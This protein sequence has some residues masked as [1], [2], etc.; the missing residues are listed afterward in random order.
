MNTRSLAV[1]LLTGIATL[2]CAKNENANTDKGNGN[3]ASSGF[4]VSATV[5]GLT[6]TGLVLTL[7]S[8]TDIAVSAN[9]TVS[10]AGS[11]AGGA[12]YAVAVKTQPVNPDQICAVAN[13]SG[14]ITGGNVTNIAIT[15]EVTGWQQ[16][17]YVKASNANGSDSFGSAVAIE[18]D[19]MVVGAYAEDSDSNTILQGSTAS[20]SNAG[21][22]NGAAYVFR[23]TGNIW[24][25]EAYLKPSNMDERDKFGWAVAISNGRIAVAAPDE[26][27]N[28]TTI[29]H[30]STASSNNT[31]ANAGAVYIFE[32]NGT[33]WEQK[34]YIKAPNAAAGH[35]FGYALAM[36]GDTLVVGA[37]GESSAQTTITNGPTASTDTSTANSG[38]VYVYRRT[39][40][41]WAQEAYIK[42]GN[43]EYLD[44]FGYS[45]SISGDAIV[46]GAYN[47]DSGQ[48]TITNGSGTSSDNSITNS[49]AVYVY[50]RSGVNWSQEAYIKAPN[51]DA[52]DLFGYM[53][54]ISGDTILVGAGGDDSGQ[55]TITNGT[56]ASTDNSVIEAGAAYIYRR[57]AG[58]WSQEAY[59]KA[60]NAESNDGFGYTIALQGNV[61][62]VSC[63]Y[64]DSS[65]TTVTNGSTASSDNSVNDTGAAFIFRRNGT[66]WS[67]EAYLKPPVAQ[68]NKW[69][70]EAG[71]SIS[72]DT[73]AVYA[74]G[75]SSNQNTITNGPTASSDT[76]MSGAGAVHVFRLK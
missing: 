64:D 21:N 43:S 69:F 13:A 42:A 72:G 19:L 37:K 54:A 55:T 20:S 8:A 59:L 30:G 46:V 41:T 17:A 32:K 29:T 5:S 76:S 71:L 61:A 31:Q 75:D 26:D 11:L 60:S 50:R 68:A 57:T 70:G 44:L 40:G 2:Q 56:T 22:T 51:P 6:G 65:Q 66:T 35:E 1:I 10:V 73:V 38:A 52:E 58:I 34:A 53:V 49:G 39:S 36:S 67:Q 14:T 48:S 15:C 12:T 28:Q 16:E 3:A 74:Y 62:V 18:G 25:Q 24:I 47:E 4:S 63:A 27:A 23:R 7:N 33:N 9:G 45:A